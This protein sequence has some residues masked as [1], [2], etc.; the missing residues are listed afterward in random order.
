MGDDFSAV[1]LPRMPPARGIL[2]ELDFETL[3]PFLK[4]GNV[5][6]MNGYKGLQMPWALDKEG[7]EFDKPSYVRRI[8]NEGGK[9]GSDGS[10]ISGEKVQSLEEAQSSIGTSSAVE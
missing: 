4:P 6:V 8:W 10:Y 2:L 9:P 7:V 1:D 3:K 5:E